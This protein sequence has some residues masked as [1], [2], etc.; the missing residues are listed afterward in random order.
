M[1][2]Y[3][4]GLVIFVVLFIDGYLL[5]YASPIKAKLKKDNK[6]YSD[7]EMAQVSDLRKAKFA[8]NVESYNKQ[9]DYF[10]D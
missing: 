8:S 6:G 7:K 2:N 3:I 10:K 5:A 4:I 9:P 1:G